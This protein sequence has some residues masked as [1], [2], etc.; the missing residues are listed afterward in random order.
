MAAFCMLFWNLYYFTFDSDGIPAHH[1]FVN[2][3]GQYG[4][5]LNSDQTIHGSK[6]QRSFLIQL[7]SP[8]LFSAPDIHLKS[9]EL[10]LVDRIVRLGSWNCFIRKLNSEWSEFTL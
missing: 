2:F 6:H 3:H 4:A 10:I 7:L 1:R 5:R 8:L 9:L